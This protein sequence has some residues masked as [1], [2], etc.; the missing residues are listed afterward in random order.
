[1]LRSPATSL[2][3]VFLVAAAVWRLHDFPQAK[4]SS[5]PWQ[6]PASAFENYPVPMAPAHP[7]ASNENGGDASGGQ[8]QFDFALLEQQ[9]AVTLAGTGELTLDDNLR[10]QF[11]SVL[12]DLPMPL[13]R[14]SLDRIEHLF[15]KS[16]PGQAGQQLSALFGPMRHYHAAQKSEAETIAALHPAGS[17]AATAAT[18]DSAQRLQAQLFGDEQ[19][20]QLFGQSNALSRYLLERRR[21]RESSTLTPEEKRVALLD[22]QQSFKA[23]E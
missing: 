23:G 5:G 4:F 7:K 11:E 1:V 19:I 2:S 17:L 12:Q 18:L 13:S 8:W 6:Q 10:R 14:E 16:F 15:R 22:L 21:V 9:F 3:L 20:R